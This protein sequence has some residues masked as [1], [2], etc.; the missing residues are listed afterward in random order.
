MRL[1]RFF[2]AQKGKGEAAMG[3]PD[4]NKLQS[5]VDSLR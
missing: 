2:C 5:K 1:L 4:Q 3:A